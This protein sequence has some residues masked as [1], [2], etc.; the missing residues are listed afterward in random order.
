[1]KL[2]QS[3]QSAAELIPDGATIM[4]GEFMGVGSSNGMLS[5][6]VFENRQRNINQEGV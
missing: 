3:A 5:P 1:M 2:V 4:I 6:V